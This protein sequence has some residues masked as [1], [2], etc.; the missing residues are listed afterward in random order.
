MKR[1]RTLTLMLLV[2]GLTACG[3]GSGDGDENDPGNGGNLVTDSVDVSVSGSLVAQDGETP[4]INATVYIPDDE[5]GEI[6]EGITCALP[7]EGFLVVTCTGVDGSFSFSAEVPEID[8]LVRAV[9][10]SFSMEVSIDPSEQGAEIDLST[11]SISTNPLASDANIAVVTGSFDDMQDVLAKT[12]LGDLN[13]FGQLE[14][15]TETFDLYDGDYSLEGEEYPLFSELFEDRGDGK[16]RLFNYDIVFI[17]C[18]AGESNWYGEESPSRNVPAADESTRATLREYVEEG[19]RLY[20]TDLAYDFVEQTFPE[21]LDF[22]GSDSTPHGEPETQDDA[23]QGRSGIT[24]DGDV[25]D[26]FLLSFLDTVDC[27][28]DCLNDDDTIPLDGFL[29]GWGVMVDAHPEKADQVKFWV[30]AD[31]HR[32]SDDLNEQGVNRPL[33]MS[34]PFGKGLVIYS[35]YH[36]HHG[37]YGGEDELDVLLPQE[38]VLQ[39]LVFE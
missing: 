36:T 2:G 28:G 18:G 1:L 19:G 39:Y 10:G 17:N 29:S 8:Q 3:G 12:G 4:L 30:S 20:V 11:V 27:G 14:L 32:Y 26:D 34:F 25:L 7:E 38:R 37:Y 21:F 16:A 24:P 15:G 22:E 23:E 13:A 33:T 9:K 35:S 31:I 6:P 5:Q